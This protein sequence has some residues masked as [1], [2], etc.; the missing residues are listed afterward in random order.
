MLKTEKDPKLIKNIKYKVPMFSFIDEVTEEIGNKISDSQKKAFE[1]FIE[2][3]KDLDGYS[4]ENVKNIMMEIREEI[5]IQ[6]RDFFQAFYL[7][8]LGKKRGPR[9]GPLM[10][11]IDK[12]WII[13]R[14]N[15]VL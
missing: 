11:M 13:D 8:F 1:L 9:L 14:L 10:E 3:S 6:A 12:K 2:K 15:S 4:N 7:V 5:D